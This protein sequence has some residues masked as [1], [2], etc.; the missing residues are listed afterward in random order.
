MYIARLIIVFTLILALMFVYTPMAREQGMQTWQTVQPTMV[1]F[2][3]GIYAAV[4]GLIAGS[5]NDNHI[6]DT[7]NYPGVNFERIIT[8]DGGFYL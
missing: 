8:M 3:D 2:M 7:P 5:G 1:E 4:R 6:D